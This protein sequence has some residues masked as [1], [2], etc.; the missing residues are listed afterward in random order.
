MGRGFLPRPHPGSVSTI[1]SN[2]RPAR[3][4]WGGPPPI[5]P[6]DKPRSGSRAAE[7]CRAEAVPSAGCAGPASTL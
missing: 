3:Q 4:G 2:G 6:R 7:R 1:P 5:P